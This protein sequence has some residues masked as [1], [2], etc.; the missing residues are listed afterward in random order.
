VVR[1]KDA[2][3][4]LDGLAVQLDGLLVLIALGVD[5]AKVVQ[6]H[7]ELVVSLTIVLFLDGECCNHRLESDAPKEGEKKNKIPF[8]YISSESWRRE[9]W[10]E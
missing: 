9:L 6:G 1:T 5:E 8:M 2:L 3:A 10:L 4:D 7:R